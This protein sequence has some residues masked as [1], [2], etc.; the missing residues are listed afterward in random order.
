MF[1]SVLLCATTL[2][3]PTLNVN[4]NQRKENSVEGNL[5]DG[6]K[7]GR[8]KLFDGDKN[9]LIDAS[10]INGKPNGTWK[11]YA[12]DGGLKSVQS[13]TDGLPSG[14]WVSV[15]PQKQ[16]RMVISHSAIN[17]PSEVAL[18]YANEVFSQYTEYSYAE[19]DTLRY[20]SYYY[21]NGNIFAYRIR[22]NMVPNGKQILY[23]EKGGKFE[24]FEFKNGKL[25]R[26]NG[27][28]SFSGKR[29]NSGTFREGA[30]KLF[31]YYPNGKLFGEENYQGGVKHDSSFYYDNDIVSA[32]GRF[33]EGKPEGYWE[34]RAWDHSVSRHYVFDTLP[35]LD[36]IV[37]GKQKDYGERTV[38]FIRDNDPD[39]T[40]ISYDIYNE[41]AE[42]I[43]Y[44]FGVPHGRYTKYFGK[45]VVAEGE[46]RFGQKYGDWNYYNTSGNISH[47]EKHFADITFDTTW[48]NT[49]EKGYR[50]LT[51]KP[52]PLEQDDLY[53]PILVKE[54][55]QDIPGTELLKTSTSP[56][57]VEPTWILVKRDI[58]LV[59]APYYKTA[60]LFSLKSHW[61]NY[62]KENTML[63]AEVVQSDSIHGMVMVRYKIDP[64][65]AVSN[66]EILK[67]M[68]H[69][70]DEAVRNTYLNLPP[71]KP[72]QLQGMAFST[73]RIEAIYF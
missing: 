3:Q 57:R 16:K 21:P 12:K 1:A 67:G 58:P 33:K 55:V 11:Y 29:Y 65:G 40:W 73:Y 52:I 24:D 43:S 45:L 64:F 60:Q 18:Y 54:W 51:N 17:K 26:V 25:H 41:P 47:N 72:A 35:G 71:F 23:H 27:M 28:F 48:R 38:G 69:G 50:L 22:K 39:S 63:D 44:K 30:G 10:F 49:P 4:N 15:T 70:V 32:F 36:Y 34:I 2:A 37:I 14:T 42:V 59:D 53:E 7:Q 13:F 6:K 9:L 62:F 56:Y 66:V 19:G 31:R 68:G 8:W 20:D 46:Y 61:I 5:I